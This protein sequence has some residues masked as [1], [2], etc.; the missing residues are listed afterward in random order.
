MMNHP[1]PKLVGTP[2]AHVSPILD[3]IRQNAKNAKSITVI[4]GYFNQNGWDLLYEH[5]SAALGRKCPVRVFADSNFLNTDYSLLFDLNESMNKEGKSFSARVFNTAEIRMLHAKVLI[6]DKPKN[7]SVVIASSANITGSAL[8][9]NLE[10]GIEIETRRTSGFYKNL[11]GIVEFLQD[12]SDEPTAEDVNRY[13]KFLPRANALK[14]ARRQ[15]EMSLQTGTG[16][17]FGNEIRRELVLDPELI[18]KIREYSKDPDV[19]ESIKSDDT[20]KA[21]REFTKLVIA[22]REVFSRLE[23]FRLLLRIYSNMLNLDD[24]EQGL[25]ELLT[26]AQSL[27]K[28]GIPIK[29]ICGYS[30]GRYHSWHRGADYDNL[31]ASRSHIKATMDL[32]ELF[33]RGNEYE[34]L[35]RAF[36]T[37]VDKTDG[38]KPNGIGHITGIL[39]ALHPDFIVCNEQTRNMAEELGQE[40]YRKILRSRSL[41]R[42]P[43]FNEIFRYMSEL[44]GID[45]RTMDR[46]VNEFYRGR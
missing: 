16:Y 26:K 13:K 28:A 3:S 42:Y 44:A 8:C 39:E 20:G 6:F 22:H 40:R 33:H 35:L 31:R 9:S 32:I 30:P 5:M 37:F 11:S 41:K 27:I 18:G 4:A 29:R 43:E 38:M 45:M 21:V 2:R 25:D 12:K 34:T 19:S 46:V 7:K 23:N 10:L 14:R 15:L 36:K 24:E 17:G 1:E